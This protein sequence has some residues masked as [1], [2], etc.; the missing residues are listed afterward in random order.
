MQQNKKWTLMVQLSFNMWTE[1]FPELEFDEE[2]Y[3]LHSYIVTL[4]LSGYELTDK[5]ISFSFEVSPVNGSSAMDYAYGYYAQVTAVSVMPVLP[6]SNILS[7]F[8]HWLHDRFD[9]LIG[10]IDYWSN[11]I[12]TALSP[13]SGQVDD[14]NEDLQ[15]SNNDLNDS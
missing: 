15:D 5:V 7:L 4:D 3:R 13:D 9:D 2:M 6:D 12:L 1:F 11:R 10:Q 8:S 14:F